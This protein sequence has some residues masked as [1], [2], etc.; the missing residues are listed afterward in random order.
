MLKRLGTAGQ[1]DKEGEAS[2]RAANAILIQTLWK[3]EHHF[4]SEAKSSVTRLFGQVAPVTHIWCLLYLLMLGRNT[5][6]TPSQS[7][8]SKKKL[9]SQV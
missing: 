8:L 2:L 4:W 1:K 5:E 6:N 7:K 3:H 9:L